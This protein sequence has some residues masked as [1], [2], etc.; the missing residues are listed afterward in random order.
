MFRKLLF[1]ALLCTAGCD[2]TSPPSIRT[3]Y[4]VNIAGAQNPPPRAS[5]D[6]S[7]VIADGV[8]YFGV[9]RSDFGVSLAA[10]KREHPELVVTAIGVDDTGGYGSTIGYFVSTEPRAQCTAK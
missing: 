5:N 10:F 1:A 3:P 7:Q 2:D 8:Y 9:N 6:L 4:A